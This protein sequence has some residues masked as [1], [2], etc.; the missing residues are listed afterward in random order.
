MEIC[1]GCDTIKAA[2]S[3]CN[4]GYYMDQHLRNTVHIN[5]LSSCLYLLL[6]KIARIRHLIDEGT[7]K[8]I[9]QALV[10]SKLDYCNCLLLG[11]A[12]YELDKLQKIQNMSC[13]IIY[14]LSKYDHVTD[15]MKELHW[16]QIRE[17]ITYKVAMLAFH[18]YTGTAPTY[19]REILPSSHGRTSLRSG[20]N[21]TMPVMRS[22]LSMVHSSSFSSMAPRIWNRLPS[23]IR[24]EKN[25]VSFKTKLKTHLF[26]ISYN[27]MD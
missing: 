7:C 23:E 22:K 21:N 2:E 6:K 13:R 5:K 27:I 1:I 4:L 25:I 3:V 15:H 12:E 26:R 16:L 11:C 24:S 10:I 17:R 20:S 8:M 9:V 14:N 19:L 18:C